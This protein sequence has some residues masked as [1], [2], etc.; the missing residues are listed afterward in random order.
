[1]WFGFRGGKGVATVVGVVGAVE[2][3]LLVPMLSC[4]FARRGAH[5]IRESRPCWPGWASSSPGRLCSRTEQRPL[6]ELCVLVAVLVIYTH[7]SNLAACARVREA[8]RD[9]YGCFDPER[10]R[11]PPLLVLLADGELHSG[12]WLAKELNVSRAAVWKGI[13]R[14]RAL[15]VEAQLPP[16]R[17][18]VYR[19]RWELLDARRIGAELGP[20]R[21]GQSCANSNCCSKW[22]RPTP[23]S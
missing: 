17:A 11:P 4:W 3:R 13:E 2:P 5:R 14:L 6:L 15:G 12:E 8:V 23:D 21:V 22:I 1:M 9:D 16:R 7:R 10:S 18:T 19:T 20:Q